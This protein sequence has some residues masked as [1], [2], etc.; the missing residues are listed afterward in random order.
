MFKADRLIIP[1]L[2]FV[3]MASLASFASAAP[4]NKYSL[5]VAR[6]YGSKPQES[7]FILGGTSATRGGETVCKNG[8]ALKSLLKGLPRGST[9]D[10]WPTCSED[11]QALAEHLDELKRICA[12]AGIEFTIHPSG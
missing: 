10:W 8:D 7:V 2:L 1:A 9:L 4:P 11:S 5:S 12:D 3:A 6:V